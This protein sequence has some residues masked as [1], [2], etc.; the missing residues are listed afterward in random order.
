V[1]ASASRALRTPS[2][3]ENSADAS[4]RAA[5]GT[6]IDR[7]YLA[8]R[9]LRPEEMTSYELGY[10]GAFPQ[11]NLSIDVKL[12][13]E[14]V[15]RLIAAAGDD[16]ITDPIASTV[17]NTFYNDGE[18][19]TDGIETQ[20]KWR[21]SMHSQL[22]LTHAY[23]FQSGQVLQRIIGGVPSYTETDLSTPELTTS[24]LVIQEFS[25][26]L[27]GS[28]GF[29]HVSNMEFFGGDET[30]GYAA[31]DARLAWKLR[32]N[33]MRGEVSLVGQNLL[34]SYFDFDSSPSSTALMD[35]RFYINLVLNFR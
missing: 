8:T 20:I 24:L 21:S 27:E 11:A 16:S 9:S 34:N 25:P 22:I 19:I 26:R 33:D 32:T 7:L 12:Y 29:Y 15:R 14:A 6:L 2:M 1:R 30:G 5:D 13:R 31:L 35:R 23:A 4:I 18:A 28:L 10:I 3:L 17:P